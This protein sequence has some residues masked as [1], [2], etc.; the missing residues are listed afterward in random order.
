MTF[1]D[2]ADFDKFKEIHESMI[3]AQDALMEFQNCFSHV[4]EEETKDWT[5]KARPSIVERKRKCH[6][7]PADVKNY[8]FPVYKFKVNFFG[9]HIW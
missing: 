5:L 4:H 2:K 9:S 8:A 1:G 7:D 6:V 3:P